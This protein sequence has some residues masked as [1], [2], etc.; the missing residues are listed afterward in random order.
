MI[1]KENIWR[2]EDLKVFSM[3]FFYG[4]IYTVLVKGGA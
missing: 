3:R 1:K 4:M 2:Y